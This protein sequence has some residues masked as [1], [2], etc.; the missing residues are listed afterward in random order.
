VNGQGCLGIYLTHDKAAAVCLDSPQTSA[1]VIACFEVSLQTESSG[2]FSELADRI[3]QLCSQRNLQFSHIAVALDCS[4]YMQHD[5]HSN[6]SDKK[7]IESTVRFDTEEALAADISDVALAFGILSSDENGSALRV[8][9]SQKTIL[10][11]VINTLAANN[12]DPVTVEPD[13]TC[14]CRFVTSRYFEKQAPPEETLFAALSQS[15]GYLVGPLR[16][17]SET[18][19]IQRT[20][21]IAPGQDRNDVF[22]RQTPLSIARLG[23]EVSLNKL[24]FLDSAGSLQGDRLASA[25]GLAAESADFTMPQDCSN[26][27]TFAVACGAALSHLQKD[28]HISFRSDYMPYLGKRR[29]FEKTLKIISVSACV[30]LVALGLNLTL[31]LMQKNKPVKLLREKLAADYA[32]ALP[33]EEKMPSKLTAAQNDLKKALNRIER[34]R[35]GQL[36]A[37]GEQSVPAKLTAVLDAFNAVASPTSLNI[38]KISITAR[39]VTITGDTSNRSNT[40]K[41]LAEIKKTMNVQQENL[42]TQGGRD[43]FSITAIPKTGG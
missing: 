25:L 6:F 26:P 14:L 19:A 15:N 29:R 1:E 31:R 5:V 17:D 39:N 36:S 37:T 13:V 12:L 34:I 18:A 38:E 23:A 11:E 43:T 41:L 27:V 33:D 9:T 2:G 30:I 42:G 16:R 20:F 32:A 21:L 24:L 3:A 22:L 8:F 28:P 10:A 7:Q 40:L 35:S 4:L